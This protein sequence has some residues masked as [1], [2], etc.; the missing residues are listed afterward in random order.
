MK[1]K[2]LYTSHDITFPGLYI[3][4]LIPL[5]TNLSEA[6]CRWERERKIW[7]VRNENMNMMNFLSLGNVVCLKK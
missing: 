2:H 4:I 5:I 7:E 6:L 1:M 3:F